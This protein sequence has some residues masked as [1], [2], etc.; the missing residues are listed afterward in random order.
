VSDSKQAGVPEIT[1]MNSNTGDIQRRKTT[2]Q[3]SI[4]RNEK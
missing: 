3:G 4:N 2:F 1:R